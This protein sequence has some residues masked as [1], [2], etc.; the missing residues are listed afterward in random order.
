M[1]RNRLLSHTYS[2]QNL[3]EQKEHRRG[4]RGAWRVLFYIPLAA[5]LQTNLSLSLSFL[6]WEIW[7]QILGSQDYTEGDNVCEGLGR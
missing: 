1:D 5:Q 7:T 4:I 2:L 3:V 6:I